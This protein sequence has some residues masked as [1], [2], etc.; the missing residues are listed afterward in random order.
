MYQEYGADEL[1]EARTLL[2]Q[3]AVGQMKEE[4]ID[5]YLATRRIK[6][7]IKFKRYLMVFRR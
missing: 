1:G 5:A 6:N 3:M 4:N 7:P 2:T